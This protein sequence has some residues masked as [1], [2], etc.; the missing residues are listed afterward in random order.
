MLEVNVVGPFL[1]TKHFLPQLQKKPTKVVVNTSSICGSISG[2]AAGGFKG[3]MLPYNSSKAAINM[4]KSFQILHASCSTAQC[5][6]HNACNTSSQGPCVDF[7]S[8]KAAINMHELLST[9]KIPCITAQCVGPLFLED[10]M[11]TSSC[12]KAAINNAL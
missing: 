8:S 3:L 1:V 9:C 12:S 5:L 7:S 4:R 2:N 11:L 6:L 10:F